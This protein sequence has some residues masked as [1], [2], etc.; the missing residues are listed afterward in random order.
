MV[1]YG[2]GRQGGIFKIYLA[3]FF[4]FFFFFPP[5]VRIGENIYVWIEF[6]CLKIFGISKKKT[7][8][9]SNYWYLITA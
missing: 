5:S 8:I 2:S 3:A 7:P 1:V 6:S 4:F 9:I